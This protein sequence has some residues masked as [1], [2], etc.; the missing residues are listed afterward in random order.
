MC[1]MATNVA[2]TSLTFPNIKN[3]VK[4][5]K[6]TILYSS[7]Y[8]YFFLSLQKNKYSKLPAYRNRM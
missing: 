1:V 7:L 5:G 3:V 6:V 2:E 8:I 4:T